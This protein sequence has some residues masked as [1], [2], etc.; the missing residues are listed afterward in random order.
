MSDREELEK[1]LQSK[2]RIEK[3]IAK[4]ESELTHLRHL[5]SLV[6]K[7]ITEKSF[8][9]AET[10]PQKAPTPQPIEERVTPPPTTKQ[11]IPLRATDGTFLGN[12][13]VEEKEI[14]VVPSDS[15]KFNVNT[16]PFHQFL[17]GK[18]LSGMVSK[19][20]NEAVSGTITPDEILTY[21][22][23][24]DGDILKEIIIR[25]Y[26]DERRAITLKNSIRWTLE[27]MYEKMK[28]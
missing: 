10:L 13:Y 15:I 18:V 1:L 25:N 14:R 19:D 5:L 23:L 21:R 3:K 7:Q 20:R 2:K 26:R 16:P 24:Q 28:L 9:V 11:V 27:K 17:V 8:K 12:I 22:I 6:E 4:Y